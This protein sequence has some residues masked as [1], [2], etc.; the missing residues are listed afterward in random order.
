MKLLSLKNKMRTSILMIILIFSQNIFSQNGEKKYSQ[1]E[2]NTDFDY[3]VNSIKE[4]HPNPY[5]V[6]SEKDFQKNAVS[7]KNQFDRPLSLKEYYK[8][9]AP[10]VA[11]LSDGH[12]SLKFPATSK[13][14]HNES[15]LFPFI[16]VCNYENSSI[17]I[18]EHLNETFAE[19]PIGSE[20]LSINNIKSKNILETII[21]NTSGENREYRLK[22]GANYMFF[23]IILNTYFNFSGDFKVSYKYNGKTYS[24]NI[25]PVTYNGF[26][27]ILKEKQKKTAKKIINETH[28]YSLILK[29]EIKT[30]IIDFKYF[31]D[32]EKF[33]VFLEKTFDSINKIGIQNLIIDIRENG[34]G[35]STLGDM[36][37]QYISPKPFN[38]FSK[39]IIKYSQLQKDFFE[40]KCKT[41]STYCSTYNY[42]KTKTNNTIETFED[43]KLIIP[44]EEEKRFKGKIF[45][46]TGIRTF[47][48]A[49][50]FAQCFKNYSLGTIIGEETGGWIVSY[51]DKIATQLPI[52]EITL[53]ISQKKFYTIG[54][55]DSDHHGVIPDIKIQSQEALN[56]TLAKIE[57]NLTKSNSKL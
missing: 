31:Y 44:F 38:Q 46:L 21:D 48:S 49:M 55:K 45:L 53:S 29:P 1:I 2:L 30:A 35:N 15:E 8:L 18:T 51:G 19:I 4:A 23:G 40:K 52:T 32:E 6:I 11:S 26:N 9:I 56:F 33:K 10:F 14:L 36:L 42:I 47:S 12:T 34:G 57:N 39:T 43:N 7:I 24:K 22:M 25:K 13:L 41:D 50:N 54:S 16:V 17:K 37:F 20:I 3:L 28:Y 5:S 27:E